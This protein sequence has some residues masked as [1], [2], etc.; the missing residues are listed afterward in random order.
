MRCKKLIKRKTRDRW[1]DYTE[2]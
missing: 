1:K 2:E